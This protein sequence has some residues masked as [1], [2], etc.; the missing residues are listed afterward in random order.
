MTRFGILCP[1][2]IGHLNPMCALGRELQRRGHTVILFG[3]LD[4]EPK[5]AQTGIE[6]HPLGEAA[7]PLGTITSIHQRLGEM[8]GLAGFN[9]TVQWIQNETQMLFN[10]APAALQA[11]NIEGLIVDQ[12]ILAGG[13]IADFLKLPFVTVSNA[14]LINREAGVPP[15]FTDWSYSPSGWAQWRNRLSN[16]FLEMLTQSARRLVWQQR[17]Q[18]HLPPYKNDDHFFSPL[19]QICQLP[20]AFDFP[21]KQLAPWFHYTGPFQDPS[22]I[23]PITFSIPPFPFDQLTDRPLIYA[24]LGTLQNR[25]PEIFEIIA[26]ACVGLDA[27]LVLALGNPIAPMADRSFPGDPLVVCYAPQ[28]QLIQR[29]S[30]VITHAGMN[31]TLAALSDGVPMVAIPITND[32]PAIA[33]RLVHTGAGEMVPLS[34][35]GVTKLRSTIQRVLKEDRYKQNAVRLQAAIA[36]AGGVRRAAEIIE[37]AISTGMPVYAIEPK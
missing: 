20:A 2:A 31:T 19:A 34:K 30:L 24:S 22:G 36:Q 3:V 1:A 7:F 13:T 25:K 35:L 14:L 21:R 32:Q 18:W 6:F 16:A 33:A 28:P 23:E 12:T 10:A 26:A 29:A 4:M 11:A 15:F 37:Q 8:T 5:L 17:Q 9:L 27:Q